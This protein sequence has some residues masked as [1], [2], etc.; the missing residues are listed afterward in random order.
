MALVNSCFTQSVKE[1]K[2][3]NP[4]HSFVIAKSV[5][6]FEDLHFY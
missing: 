4:F 2:G 6:T 3:S 5:F 1:Q